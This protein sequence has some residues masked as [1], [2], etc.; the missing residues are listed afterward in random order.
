MVVRKHGRDQCFQLH[1][2]PEW[3][4]PLKLQRQR[5][6]DELAKQGQANLIT[7]MFDLSLIY[8]PLDVLSSTK[9]Y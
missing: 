5:E 3:W 8:D 9:L 1:G 2:Y 4:E 7:S 6:R